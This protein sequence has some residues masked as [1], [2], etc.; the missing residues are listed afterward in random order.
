MKFRS[1][2]TTFRAAC[3]LVLLVALM[4]VV[5]SACA[6]DSSSATSPS[7]EPAGATSTTASSPADTTTS[8][9]GP[10]ITLSNYQTELAHT[11][12]VWT[13][14]AQQLTDEGAAQDDPRMALIFGLR[15]RTQALS[16]RQALAEGDLTLAQQAMIDVYA[17]I[18]R[19]RDVAEGSV[20]QRLT[21]AHAVIETLGDPSDD[22]Q[23]AATLLDAF[24]AALAPLL[25]EAEAMTATTTAT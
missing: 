21:E 8:S 25:D 19:G 12:K 4:A 5:L 13:A 15:A 6:G 11:A 18:N 14:L 17:T 1:P 20:A 24:I 2:I 7:S 16:G 10:P 9:T 23:R 3:L 22:P